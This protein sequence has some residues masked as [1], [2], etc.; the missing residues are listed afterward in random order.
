MATVTP[1]TGMSTTDGT[2]GIGRAHESAAAIAD[3]GRAARRAVGAPR[4][5][6]QA[7]SRN[8]TRDGEAAVARSHGEPQLNGDRRR[9]QRHAEVRHDRPRGSLEPAAWNTGAQVIVGLHHVQVAAPPGCELRAR[10]FYGGLLG[11]EEVEKPAALASRGGCWFRAGSHEL[12]VGVADPFVPAEK[13]H[14]ALV[15]SS[16]DALLELAR[17]LGE[18]GTTVSWAD[19]TEIPHVTRVHVHDPFGNR[20]ELLA[21]HDE[22]G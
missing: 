14:P 4:V 8:D 5:R 3:C 22:P 10:A 20:L 7:R 18:G 21:R 1:E 17:R 2:P 6:R 16:C 11:L 15:V 12:H 19:E 9:G 13:A